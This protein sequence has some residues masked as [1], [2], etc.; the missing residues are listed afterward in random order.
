[1]VKKSASIGNKWIIFSLS[2]ILS[3]THM[4]SYK[5][6]SLETGQRWM[7]GSLHVARVIRDIS[8]LSGGLL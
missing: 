4:P 8:L 5:G 3:I 2:H 6:Q 7:Y 1:M